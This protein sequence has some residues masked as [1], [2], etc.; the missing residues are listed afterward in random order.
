MVT[1]LTSGVIISVDVVDAKN[2][3]GQLADQVENAKA[4][5]EQVNAQST[6]DN[7]NSGVEDEVDNDKDIRTNS[8]HAMVADSGYFDTGKIAELTNDGIEMNVSKRINNGGNEGRTEE[9]NRV[10]VN[11]NV[12]RRR[13]VDEV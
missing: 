13:K 3:Q 11:R 2:D 8:I 1:D 6:V 5:L 7:S 10:R 4:V 9:F 12:V